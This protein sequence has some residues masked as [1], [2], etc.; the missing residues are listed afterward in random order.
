M[1]NLHR[2]VTARLGQMYRERLLVGFDRLMGL[3]VIPVSRSF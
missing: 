3:G 2:Q 1:V